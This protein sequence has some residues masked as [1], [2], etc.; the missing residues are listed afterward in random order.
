MLGVYPEDLFHRV[1]IH[2]N[3]SVFNGYDHL[4]ILPIDI[5]LYG[6][7]FRG[8]FYRVGNQVSDNGADGVF[9]CAHKD[10]LPGVRHERDAL[11]VGLRVEQLLIFLQ[12]G[13]KI[14]W[15]WSKLDGSCLRPRPF[16]QVLKKSAE[17]FYRLVKILGQGLDFSPAAVVHMIDQQFRKRGK[18]IERASQVTADDGKELVF[19]GVKLL[20]LQIL[21]LD[22]VV[23]YLQVSVRFLLLHIR[24]KNQH[25]NDEDQGD[26]SVKKIPDRLLGFEFFFT[27]LTIRF[28]L[29]DL[30]LF[31]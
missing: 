22:P 25:H 24:V 20:Q 6:T 31:L 13:G 4:P 8:E 26:Q 7:A 17:S 10:S 16:Q 29:A 28:K 23:G 2:S 12:Q 21:V 15:L 18:R 1:G 27:L 5:Q 14:K 9:V 11:A 30:R 3:A 19:R